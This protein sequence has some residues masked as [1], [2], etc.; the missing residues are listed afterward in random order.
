MVTGAPDIRFYAGAPL[1]S[2]KGHALD[3]A[4]HRRRGPRLDDDGA[5][6]ATWPTPSSSRA[7]QDHH[8]DQQ[9]ALLAL[10]AI[11]ALADT[12]PRDQ[13]R[14][15]LELGSGFLGL[16]I[17]IVSR[18]DGDDY[19][20][21]VQVSPTGCSP[22]ARTSPSR[23]PTASSP[24]RHRRRPRDRPHGHVRVL[25]HPCYDAFGLESYIG[26]SHRINDQ[27]FG[28]LNFSAPDPGP[29]RS[30]PRPT[31]ISCRSWGSSVA[32][33]SLRRWRNC[34][35]ASPGGRADRRGHRAR[36]VESF[37]QTDDRTTA[38]DRLCRTSC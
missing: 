29:P 31:S 28:T 3:R 2:M 14:E 38:F 33:N 26:M 24:Y 9:Q 18:I 32:A 36:A 22:T 11:T 37:I 30:S 13:L 19:E 23:A 27:L 25:R 21:I 8:H 6:C 12:N 5:H 16:P 20:V 1:A 34:A 35:A 10:T 15:A 17:G 4:R 7:E